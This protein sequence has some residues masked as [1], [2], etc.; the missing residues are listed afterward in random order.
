M[1]E[2]YKSIRESDVMQEQAKALQDKFRK[3]NYIS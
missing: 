3:L 2:I 1:E